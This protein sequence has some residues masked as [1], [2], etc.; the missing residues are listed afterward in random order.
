MANR[1]K[2]LL[3]ISP[4]RSGINNDF[5]SLIVGVFPLHL[6]SSAISFFSELSH[7]LPIGV[8]PF[9]MPST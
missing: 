1:V 7:F 4:T 8:P 9:G 3:N 5:S 6:V 2:I